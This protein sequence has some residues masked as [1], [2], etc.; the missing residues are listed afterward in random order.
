MPHHLLGHVV[1]GEPVLF[2]QPPEFSG[3]TA[4][5]NGRAVTTGHLLLSHAKRTVAGEY[6]GRCLMAVAKV[7]AAR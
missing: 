4:A 2:T 3:E 6:L 7:S 5:S 1:D